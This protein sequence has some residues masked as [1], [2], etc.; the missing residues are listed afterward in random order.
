MKRKQSLLL[1]LLIISIVSIF[2]LSSCEVTLRTATKAEINEDGELIINYSD[3]TQ[4]NLGVVVGKDGTNGTNG[5]DG[6]DGIDGT[7]GADGKDGSINITNNT[8]NSIALA[9]SKGFKSSVSIYCTYQ[10]YSG[11]GTLTTETNSAGSG[12]IYKLDKENGD[13]LII[14]NYH[15]VYDPSSVNKNGISEKIQVF[16]Y[17]SETIDSVMEAT[18]VGGSMYYDIAVLQIKNSDI[19]K[20]HDVEAVTIRNSDTIHVGETAIALGNPRGTGLATSSGII[21]VDSEYL[22][23]KGADDVTDVSFRVMRVDT[24]I[25]GGNSGGGLFDI[26]GKLIGIVNAKCVESDID[27]IGYAIPTN[28]AIGAVENILYY[29]LGT[30]QEN[31]KKPLVGITVQGK[32]PYAEYDES[33]GYTNLFEDVTVISVS[34]GSLADGVLKADDV[35]KHVKVNDYD[36]DITRMYMLIDSILHARIG[37]TITLTFERDGVTHQESFTITDKNVILY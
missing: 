34:E 5:T 16:L 1:L 6:K 3:G 15:V 13:A 31:V 35:I 10:V 14:T 9:S 19:L 22:D 7:N 37:D 28:V 4:D 29:C 25:N 33:T 8:D 21:S 17:G 23:M 36:K 12:V 30:T 18:Y 26:E 24:P 32:N 20:R 11:Y 27:N 2:V